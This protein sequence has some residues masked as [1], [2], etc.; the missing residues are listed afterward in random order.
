MK[1]VDNYLSSFC[2][3]LK[4]VSLIPQRRNDEKSINPRYEYA[5]Q[6]IEIL[7]TVNESDIFFVDEVGFNV[8]MRCKKGRSLIDTP[9]VK[10]VP[11]SRNISICCAITK[12][13][14]IDF[15]CQTT[16]FK[17]ESFTKFIDNLLTHKYEKHS[18][19]RYNS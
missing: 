15:T 11:G 16:A 9:A 7:S 10:I 1:T 12:E 6:F 17:T 4:N 18:K 13:G 5:M 19:S 8:S 2:Y 14:I 3:S